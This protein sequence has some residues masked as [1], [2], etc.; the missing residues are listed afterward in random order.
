MNICM[1]LYIKISSVTMT[2]TSN[3]VTWKLI[4]IIYF[5]EDW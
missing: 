4:E 3:Y 1:F 5:L 2:L